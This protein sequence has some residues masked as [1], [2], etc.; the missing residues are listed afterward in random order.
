MNKWETQYVIKKKIEEGKK[1]EGLNIVAILEAVE[2]QRE[3][4]YK[5]LTVSISVNLHQS[6]HQEVETQRE[7]QYKYLRILISL[8]PIS[9]PCL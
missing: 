9:S 4:Q 8:T 5:Y 3:A 6:H 1:L 7:A 2:T